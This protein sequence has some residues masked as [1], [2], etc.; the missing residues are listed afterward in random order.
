M[1]LPHST[2]WLP[3]ETFL[4]L[5]PYH[6]G[7]TK[8]KCSI[9]PVK[10]NR[11]F[12]DLWWSWV[13]HFYQRKGKKC[14]VKSS[15]NFF[16]FKTVCAFYQRRKQ[17]PLSS[18]SIYVYLVT[19][20]DNGKLSPHMQWNK[21]AC[22]PSPCAAHISTVPLQ[23]H[24]QG[25]GKRTAVTAH[26]LQ[27]AFPQCLHREQQPKRKRKIKS[28]SHHQFTRDSERGNKDSTW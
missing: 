8:P 14:N 22:V 2:P 11:C 6:T 27:A 10:S 16:F 12:Y 9:L 1:G 25:R 28:V 7:K 26:I 17:A 23:E 3:W 24:T 13:M 21:A 20:G 18:I 4:S 15:S 5:P 19:N